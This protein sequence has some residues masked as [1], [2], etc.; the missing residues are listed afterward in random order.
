MGF[1]FLKYQNLKKK[2]NRILLIFLIFSLTGW[3]NVKL[4]WFFITSSWTCENYRFFQ[5]QPENFHLNFQLLILMQFKFSTVT[6]LTVK[7]L[8]CAPRRNKIQ[9]MTYQRRQYCPIW[10]RYYIIFFPIRN[11][12]CFIITWCYYCTIH[13]I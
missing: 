6:F 1:H 13:I 7:I 3:K 11:W 2:S 4:Q 5:N 10:R 12:G 9:N 8:K